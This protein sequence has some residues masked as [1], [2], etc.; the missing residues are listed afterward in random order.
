MFLFAA[1]NVDHNNRDLYFRSDKGKP[2]VYSVRVL[3][4]FLGGDVCTRLLFAHA[5][6]GSDTTSRIFGVGKN[7]CFRK[8]SRDILSCVPVPRFSLIHRQNRLLWK[9]LGVKLWCHCSTEQSLTLWPQLG[10][11][12]CAK[13]VTTAKTLVTPERLPPTNSA[14]I[15]HARRTYLQVMVWMGCSKNMDPTKWGLDLQGDKLI[16]VY[17]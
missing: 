3:K 11:V 6:T 9:V 4:Q 12:F 5:F 15:H 2:T 7:Q 8:S 16:P 10:I 14:T 13:K 17:C 1:D